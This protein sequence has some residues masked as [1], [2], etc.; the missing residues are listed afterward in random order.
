MLAS[1]E[2]EIEMGLDEFRMIRDFIH[3]KS[4]IYFAENKMHV[5][6][7]RLAK[8]M[9]ELD[10]K[11]VRDYFYRVK[12]DASL[13]EFNRL[14]D[15]VTTNETSFFRNRP[16]LLS[17]ST[18]IIPSILKHKQDRGAP[19]RI[20]VWSAGCSTGEEPYTLAILLKECSE[21]LDEWSL[22]IIA[23]DISQRVLRKARLAEYAGPT[24]HDIP[25]DALGRYFTPADGSYRVRPEIKT[26]VKFSHMNLNDPRMISLISGVD[27]VFCRNVM[28]YFSHEAK[29][30]LVRAFYNALRPGGY[31]YVG[32]AESLHGISKAFKLAYFRNALVYLKEAAAAPG[33]AAPVP[34]REL[35]PARATVGLGGA[36]PWAAAGVLSPPA[37]VKHEP[38]NG[39]SVTGE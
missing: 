22:E 20:K 28:A 13:C 4:G 18:E 12:Y 24:L 2:H 33:R 37:G 36:E 8:R 34:A 11:A 17:F 16:Q 38:V 32:H 9:A 35:Q 19:R 30:R 10:L 26:L 31:L 3:E 15:L 1:F 29:K 21:H 23:N 27:V 14:M 5:V 25:S 7:N 39:V 6:K